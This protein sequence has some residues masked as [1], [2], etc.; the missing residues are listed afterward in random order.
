MVVPVRERV[1]PISAT[2]RMMNGMERAMFTTCPMT[3][4][5]TTFWSSPPRSVRTSRMPSG[6]PPTTE[7]NVAQPTM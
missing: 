7:M 1:K 5:A 3:L 2:I 6:S 4:L